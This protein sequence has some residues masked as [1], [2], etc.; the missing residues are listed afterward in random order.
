MKTRIGE[1][2]FLVGVILAV[3]AGLVM[4]TGGWVA[5]VLVILGLIVG[6]L[7]ISAKETTPFLVSAIALLM[8][9]SAGLE[10]LPIIGVFLGPIIANILHFVAPAV[11]I[12]ALK[13][14]FDLAK[15]R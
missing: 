6:F 10:T 4:L 12:V 9:G 1:Y 13:T 7:N 14:V 3:L 11:V 15:K 2:A 5:V 8:A